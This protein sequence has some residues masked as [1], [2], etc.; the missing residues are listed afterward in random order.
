MNKKISETIEYLK[1][2][3]NNRNEFY[4][5]ILKEGLTPKEILDNAIFDG[6]EKPRGSYYCFFSNRI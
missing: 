3:V 1:P 4:N 5:S 2:F 6:K